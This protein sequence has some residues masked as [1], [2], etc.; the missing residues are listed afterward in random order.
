M[1][2]KI[3]RKVSWLVLIAFLLA[4]MNP[5]AH[6]QGVMTPMAALSAP[7][8]LCLLRGMKV[9]VREPLQF[10][11]LF[12][13]GDKELSADAF[14]AQS[15]RLVRYFMA[16]LT[17][18]QQDLWVNLSPYENNRIVQE[19]LGRTGM[20]RDLLNQDYILKQ[21]AASLLYPDSATGK[22]FWAEVYSRAHEKFGTTDIPIDTFNK[23]WIVPQESVVYESLSKDKKD[24]SGFVD[25]V[26]LKV[27]LESDYFAKNSD[28]AKGPL[29]ESIQEDKSDSSQEMSKDVIR[30]VVLP[31][32]EK[33]V[34]EGA[35]FAPL[36]QICY[37]LVLSVWFKKKLAESAAQ[38]AGQEVKGNNI[39][40]MVYVNQHKTEGIEILDPKAQTQQIYEDYLQAYKKGAYDLIREE[41]DIYS[42]ELIPRKYFSGG[43][44]A[45]QVDRAMEIKGGNEWKGPPKRRLRQSERP[46]IRINSYVQQVQRFRIE[47]IGFKPFF[48]KAIRTGAYW[49]AVTL[50]SLSV[51]GG[52]W[53]WSKSG[54]ELPSF[55]K[56]TINVQ[57]PLVVEQEPVVQPAEEPEVS[58]PETVSSPVPI[59]RKITELISMM[60][61]TTSGFQMYQSGL[62]NGPAK[63]ITVEDLLKGLFQ[64][65]DDSRGTEVVENLSPIFYGL[66]SRNLDVFGPQ[67]KANK[68]D[69]IRLGRLFTSFALVESGGVI[70][71]KQLH[72]KHVKGLSALQIE[73]KTWIT[74][75]FVARNA[76][77]DLPLDIK[78]S[79][80]I[81]ILEMEI[82]KE[83]QEPSGSK[84]GNEWLDIP[85]GEGPGNLD[86]LVPVFTIWMNKVFL[87]KGMTIE[88]I[89]LKA[90]KNIGIKW[91]SNEA[92]ALDVRG[93]AFND[94]VKTF[95]A[96]GFES[97]AYASYVWNAGDGLSKDE[98]RRIAKMSSSDTNKRMEYKKNARNAL[99][100]DVKNR[101]AYIKNVI[102]SLPDKVFTK[103]HSRLP[104][105]FKINPSRMTLYNEILSELGRDQGNKFQDNWFVYRVKGELP[106]LRSIRDYRASRTV[107]YVK[108]MTSIGLLADASPFDV[109]LARRGK[110]EKIDNI[111]DL[112]D[113]IQKNLLA[114]AMNKRTG[115]SSVKV[116]G[117]VKKGSSRLKGGKG[118][119][120]HSQ[121]GGIDL[122]AQAQV[123]NVRGQAGVLEMSLSADQMVYMKDDIQGFEPIV[124]HT[125]IVRDVGQFMGFAPNR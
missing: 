42:Q 109:G 105:L 51:A 11:F 90:E 106:M 43:F 50:V 122:T 27:M 81:K 30:Q 75:L 100:Q 99:V 114:E 47:K 119:K 16:S 86:V 98:W 62:I 1:L 10:D 3:Y 39:L 73:Y 13:E 41:V 65:Y 110:I 33:E 7:V 58:V 71:A 111:S 89:L 17:I 25:Q 6:A 55:S 29:A 118:A 63:R 49:G 72:K 93:A 32:L 46:I 37:A 104:E 36:R 19:D 69:A 8:E 88:E 45:A 34:N 70:D 23:V 44:D 74:M 28:V 82:N 15:S 92:G 87:E 115:K 5:C 22:A 91:N 120:D 64:R 101:V 21:V 113:G 97:E 66:L 61:K 31:I 52:L 103:Y 14:K 125:E 56:P 108:V 35:N 85:V 24:I 18:P 59:E 94:L 123:M 53:Q 84:K 2:R 83:L 67:L 124:L 4:S 80:D 96:E 12:D 48:K 54:W 68:Y 77:N 78:A 95:E 117:K 107:E 76:I 40:S 79:V 38:A 57:E 116:L 26:K 121:V 20:G 102:H 112:I 60:E 9:N